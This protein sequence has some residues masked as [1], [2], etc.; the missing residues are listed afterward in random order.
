VGGYV[1]EC[2]RAGDKFKAAYAS[3]VGGVKSEIE[4]AMSRVDQAL[5]NACAGQ[6]DRAL[7]ESESSAKSLALARELGK[8]EILKGGMAD[9]TESVDKLKTQIREKVEKAKKA[10]EE[11]WKPYTSVLGG[12]KLKYF[13]DNYRCGTNVYGK[14]GGQITEPQQF[15]NASLMCSYS[16]DR[17]G[18]TPRWETTCRRF[19]GN[20]QVGDARRDSGW[21]D[22]PPSDAFK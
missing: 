18:V 2:L 17:N 3:L 10:D 4:A 8:I 19:D 5:E 20:K 21:G 11:K 16:V 13:N 15:K 6:F 1:E 9:L 7:Q 14:G 22:R 12:D